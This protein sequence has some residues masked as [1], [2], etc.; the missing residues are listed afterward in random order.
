MERGDA[1]RLPVR[2]RTRNCRPRDQGRRCG[3]RLQTRRPRRG[4][5]CGFGPHLPECQAGLEQFCPNLTLTYSLPDQRS[6]RP[7]LRRLLGKRG[8]GRTFRAPRARLTWDLAQRTH[9]CLRPRPLT[10]PWWCRQRE[11]ESREWS[12]WAAWA[13]AVKFTHAAGRPRGG[14]HYFARQ[15]ADALRLGADEVVVSRNAGEM[16]KHHRQL[17]LHSL[18]LPD[19]PP[20]TTSTPTSN[21]SG[22]IGEF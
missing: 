11:E 3:Q 9:S 2:P 6:Q 15:E 13:V 10:H 7:N 16:S 19:L 17:R 4:A 5:P 18:E 22:A 14:L 12:G 20:T 1:H 8:G 21:C